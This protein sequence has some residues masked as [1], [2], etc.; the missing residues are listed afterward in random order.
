MN[1]MVRLSDANVVMVQSIEDSIEGCV[2]G[3]T[4]WV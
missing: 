2:E 1:V 3:H 4:R